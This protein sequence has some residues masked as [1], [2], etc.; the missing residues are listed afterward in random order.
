MSRK[1]EIIGRKKIAFNNIE[2]ISLSFSRELD[3]SFKMFF[4]PRFLGSIHL[5]NIT[6]CH[7]YP[8]TEFAKKRTSREITQSIKNLTFNPFTKYLIVLMIIFNILWIVL[9]YL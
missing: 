9:I 8:F 3:N 4:Q 5:K 6:S 7:D 1:Q 2:K